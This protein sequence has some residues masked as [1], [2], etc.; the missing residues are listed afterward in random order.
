MATAW[1]NDELWIGPDNDPWVLLEVAI[2]FVENLTNHGLLYM[3][4]FYKHQNQHSYSLHALFEA[5]GNE[6]FAFFQGML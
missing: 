6:E 3:F 2:A 1:D 4:I 5:N